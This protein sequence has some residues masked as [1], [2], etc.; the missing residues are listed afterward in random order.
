MNRVWIFT[1]S[2]PLSETEL[3]QLET[4]GRNFVTHWTAH[5]RQLDGS[6]DIFGGRLIIVKVNESAGTASGCSIDKLNRFMKV[7]ESMFGIS[8]LDRMLVAYAKDSG[9]EVVPAAQVKDLLSQGVL[10]ENTPVYNTA[11]STAE[12]LSGWIQPLRET[13]LKKYLSRI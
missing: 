5:D 11:A 1:M 4:A 8:L 10:D 9:V 6:F 3:S 13:W 2:K 7:S 12:E